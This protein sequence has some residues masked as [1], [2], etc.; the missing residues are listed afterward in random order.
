MFCNTTDAVT[1]LRKAWACSYKTIDSR[2]VSGDAALLI[3]PFWPVVGCVN[4]HGQDFN[5]IHDLVV[6]RFGNSSLE[7]DNLSRV[8]GLNLLRNSNSGYLYAVQEYSPGTNKIHS[9]KRSEVFYSGLESHTDR[10]WL[11]LAWKRATGSDNYRRTIL[12]FAQ[13]GNRK[14]V[15]PNEWPTRT[16]GNLR[17]FDHLI[18]LPTVYASQ[19][20]TDN[21]QQSVE[22]NLRPINSLPPFHR[23]TLAMGMI[24]A[25]IGM[26]CL[27]RHGGPVSGIAAIFGILCF[28]VGAILA[29]WSV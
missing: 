20:Y 18:K 25:L 13:V 19:F 10:P 21:E 4:V 23:L 24:I 16:L 7:T 9:G 17:L 27:L 29:L 14:T 1:G 3:V 6:V 8:D 2:L 22:N 26:A 28:A 5:L 11:T 15:N 12:A